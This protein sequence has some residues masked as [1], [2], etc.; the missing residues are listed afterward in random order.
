M[1]HNEVITDRLILR[2]PTERDVDE[3]FALTGDPRVWEHFPALRH[4][5]REQA[6]ALVERWSAQWDADGLSTW[7]VR[8]RPEGPV[9]G[10]GGCS[11]LA[12]SVWNLGYRF[13]PAVQGRGYA[14]EVSLAALTH[15]RASNATLPVVAYLLEHNLASAQVAHKV[16]LRL[17]HRAPDA[18]N[19]DPDAMRLV[20]AE[21]PLSIEELRVALR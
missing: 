14:T 5:R 6:A 15:A 11:V 13:S 16:G 12:G 18:G 4:T 2:R 20:Y 19:P 1:H 7:V 9:V 21:R 17:V 8:E 10:Y 3:L